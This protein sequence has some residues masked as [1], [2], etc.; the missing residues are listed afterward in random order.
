[1]RLREQL[2]P[3]AGPIR[4][5]VRANL[6]RSV[7]NGILVSLVVLFFVRSVGLPPGQLGIG[8]TIAAAVK[9][10][11]SVPTGHLVDVLGPRTSAVGFVSLQGLL[12][13]GYTLADG[14]AGFVVAAALV[15]VAEVAGESARGA[16]VAA[17]VAGGERVR[18]RAY[19]RA[20]NNIGI[21]AGAVFG[22]VALSIDSRAGYVS[23][24]VACGLLF[25]AS[26][27][28]YL[29]LP[30][31]A[32]VGRGERAR[33]W[34]VL[35]DRPF[36]AA[37]VI[38]AV[39]MMNAGILTVALPIWIAARTNA[40]AYVYSVILVVNTVMVVAFQVR[41]SRGAEDVMGGANA[42]RRC[43]V[44]LAVCCGL[45]ALAAG[46]PAWLAVVL[47]G[48]GALVHVFGELLYS[49]G[50]WALAYELAPEHAHGQ[51]Q[52]MFG[53]SGNIGAMLTPVAATTLIVGAGWLGWLVFAVVLLGAGTAAPAVGKWALRTRQEPVAA[54]N[55]G[56]S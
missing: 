3:P 45:F 30:P 17:V 11:A 35:G 24:L 33:W 43:G 23:L 18:A 40:P 48:A 22:G 28:S 14:F 9:I 5:L 2:I 55:G 41:M 29:A 25:V 36:V 47:L 19:L 6:G 42:L 12:V 32:P 54:S 7:G 44:L 15:G 53:M 20:V 49:A 1:M 50:S 37:S 46:Q 8:L 56:K 21:S 27:L 51:Y 39:L 26:G 4:A 10:L 38:N 16:L 52:G 34:A 31:V 13:T